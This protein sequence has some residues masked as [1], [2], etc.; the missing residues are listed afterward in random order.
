[1]PVEEGR[2]FSTALR[3]V[4]SQPVC[5]AEIPDAQHAFE[6][7]RSVRGHHTLRAVRDFLNTIYQRERGGAPTGEGAQRT[8]GETPLSPGL[9]VASMVSARARTM[10]ADSAL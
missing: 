8:L 7:F 9:N 5:Y 10:A 3:D 1:M 2:R 6:I 4:S